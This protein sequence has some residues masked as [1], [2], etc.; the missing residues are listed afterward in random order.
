M[1]QSENTIRTELDGQ[2][3]VITI[4]RVEARNAFDLATA[5]QMEAALDR[6]DEDGEARVGIIT[7]AGG[8]FCAGQDLKAAAR[9][10][11][12]VTERRGP[13]GVMTRPSMKPLIAAV[14]GPAL[15]GGFELALSCD[16]IVASRASSFGLPEVKRN[17]V[18]VG[19]GAL[20]LPR[21]MP[22]HLAMEMIL[23]GDPVGAEAMRGHGIV[24]RV[25][26]PGQALAGALDLARVLAANGPLA[27]KASKEIAFRC[28]AEGWTEADGWREQMKIAGPVFASED[29]KEG[30]AAF[31]EKR[32]PVWR[33]R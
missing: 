17:L 27:L 3:L 32:A 24:N 19:G 2:V 31:A 22:Y 29:F 7:G 23:T 25:V 20:R 30:L 9:G 14:E 5:R 16:L 33:G 4:D 8:V 12:A 11:G 13:F 28:Q 1:S 26:E 6:L 21:R 18:A 10:E 15:A